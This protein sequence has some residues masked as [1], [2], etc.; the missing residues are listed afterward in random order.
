MIEP[1][2]NRA[3]WNLSEEGIALHR[4]LWKLGKRLKEEIAAGRMKEENAIDKMKAAATFVEL[5]Y[6]RSLGH[7][8]AKPEVSALEFVFTHGG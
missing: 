3:A 4:D 2:K 7:R 8:E 5:C 6:E 1:S